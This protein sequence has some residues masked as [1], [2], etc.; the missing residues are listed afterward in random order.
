MLT[1][2]GHMIVEE[3]NDRVADRLMDSAKIDLVLAGVDPTD[4]DVLKWVRTLRRKRKD[5]PVILLSKRLRPGRTTNRLRLGTVTALKYPVPAAVL[6]AA[7]LHALGQSAIQPE[8]AAFDLAALL[9]AS[10]RDIAQN[11]TQRV[12]KSRTAVP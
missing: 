11:R 1:S 9:L 2:E 12:R 3:A 5:V 4:R 6:R 8:A 10:G 7:V